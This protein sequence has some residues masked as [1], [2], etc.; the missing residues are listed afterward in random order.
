MAAVALPCFA[1]TSEAGCIVAGRLGDAGWA[2]RMQGVQLLAQDGSAVS[3]A[4][5][6]ALAGVK[7]VRLS[8]PALL[9]RCDGSNALA[10]GPDVPGA[11]N[12]VPAIGP[13]TI[14]VE[15]VSFPR[16]RRGGELVELRLT[17]PAERVT[18]V[19]Q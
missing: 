15:S 13:G 1:Q 18:M 8:A 7:Q 9:S 3:A 11:R 4:S 17:V 6:S 2:P 10:L 19:T 16:L 14:P 5:K 12:K